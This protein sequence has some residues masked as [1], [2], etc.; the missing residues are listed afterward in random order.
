MEFAAARAEPLERAWAL[1]VTDPRHG[2]RRPIPDGGGPATTGPGCWRDT[3]TLRRH[4]AISPTRHAEFR[5]ARQDPESLLAGYND[6]RTARWRVPR[7][8]FIALN[9]DPGSAALAAA[10]ERHS[11]IRPGTDA[12]RAVIPMTPLRRDQYAI[13][14]CPRGTRSPMGAQLRR[15]QGPSRRRRRRCWREAGDGKLDHRGLARRDRRHRGA[16]RGVVLEPCGGA[17]GA[18]PWLGAP[19]GLGDLRLGA[20]RRLARSLRR[21]A[22]PTTRPQPPVRRERQHVRAPSE[23]AEWRKGVIGGLELAPW[24]WRALAALVDY[25]PLFILAEMVAAASATLAWLLLIVVIGVNSVVL[26]GRTGQS[27]GKWLFGL[28]LAV[29]VRT[30]SGDQ[31]LVLPGVGAR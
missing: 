17:H 1:A 8:L 21:G 13:G 29:P 16:D 6:T 9:R 27:F 19:R 18:A 5:E 24:K 7:R 10:L 3:A 12:D 25:L 4:C 22:F 2:Q 26:P 15:S 20:E 31:E 28:Q 14:G 11:E 23:E 30:R